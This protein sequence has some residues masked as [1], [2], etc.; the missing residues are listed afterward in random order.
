MATPK[1]TLQ[2][3][4]NYADVRING[5]RPWDIRVHNKKFYRRVLS[6][7]TLGLGESY[8]DGW[9]D[10]PELDQ[11]FERV[12]GAQLSKKVY[13]KWGIIF[14]ILKNQL[15]NLQNIRL[16]KRVAKE[17]YD[18][19]NE[20]YKHMLD[21]N[22]QYTC[23]YWKDAKT[24]DK[25]Q[26]Q[27]LDL[28]CKKLQLQPGDRVLELGCGFGGF[29]KYAAEKYKVHVTGYNISKEQVD[30]ARE[31]CKGLPV[32]IHLKDYRKAKGKFDKVVA[33]GLCEHIGSKNY[34]SFMKLARRRM[35][36]DGLFLVHTIGKTRT[37][38]YTDPWLTKYIFPHG[39]LPSGKRL[40]K[41]AEDV[42][43][44]EDWHNFGA[45]YDKTLMAWY[46]NFDK[47]WPKFREEYG[48][49]F[50]RMWKYYLLSCAGSFRARNL[51][52]LW[53]IVYSKNGIPGGYN[54]IR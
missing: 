15:F 47:H 49:R 40:S 36:D 43:V 9:W 48:E 52:E 33:I 24:L 27:K 42:L 16:S 5:D 23:A 28:I 4:L 1:Q 2:K 13:N 17:H 20:F 22:M 10:V 35:T 32:E 50:Y 11:L 29:A 30:Y 3:L 37:P 46:A 39:L 6:Q 18:I 45:D 21:K 14:I 41:A 51:H 7:G 38:F 19:G 12:I 44:M 54:S 31:Q 34:R 26:E 53:Q 25:A 8:M